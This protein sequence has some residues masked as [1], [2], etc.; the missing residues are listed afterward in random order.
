MSP[1]TARDIHAAE[2][3]TNAGDITTGQVSAGA[4]VGA[5]P[6]WK[7]DIRASK[8][9]SHW[10]DRLEGLIA[11][12]IRD[13]ARDR[14]KRTKHPIADSNVHMPAAESVFTQFL[15]ARKSRAR[16]DSVGEAIRIAPANHSSPFM[17]PPQQGR[18][19]EQFVPPMQGLA[20]K[21]EFLPLQN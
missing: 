15:A 14:N 17:A 6:T 18:A 13:L 12:L 1:T 3:A 10:L 2:D 9:G 16:V 7:R 20:V 21:Q 4:S 8:D 11:S 5:I 19:P